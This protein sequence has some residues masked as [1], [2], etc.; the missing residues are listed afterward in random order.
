MGAVSFAYKGNEL[1]SNKQGDHVRF[2]LF[3]R[4][5]VIFCYTVY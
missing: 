5:I 3:L 2:D 4:M 1:I